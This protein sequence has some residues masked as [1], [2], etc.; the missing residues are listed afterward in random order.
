MASLLTYVIQIMN[1][2]LCE[3]TEQA[4]L[5][6]SYVQR[7]HTTVQNRVEM[8]YQVFQQLERYE[9]YREVIM[10]QKPQSNSG[11]FSLFGLLGSDSGSNNNVELLKQVDS[12]LRHIPFQL[13]EIESRAD[14]CSPMLKH[15]TDI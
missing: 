3:Y 14:L 8:I 10:I 6:L 12:L 7:F 4:C 15:I 11:I 2:I 9:V 1:A 13:S 5:N